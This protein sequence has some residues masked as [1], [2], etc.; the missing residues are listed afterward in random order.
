MKVIKE[1]LDELVP[2]LTVINNQSLQSGVFPNVWKEDLVT[3]TITKCGFDLAFKN[4]R[5]VSNL[6][7]A[8]KLVERAAAEQ[9]QSHLVKN[10][11]FPTLQSAYRPNHS[12]ETALLKSKMTIYGIWIKNTLRFLSFR[13]SAPPLTRL[14]S[15]SPKPYTHRILCIWK[16]VRLVRLVLIK[17]FSE[18]YSWWYIIRPVWY[19]LWGIPRQLPWSSVIRHLF[20]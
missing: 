4:F 15:N 1:C 12:T 10:N 20:Q 13:T 6:Q 9:L 7:F 18:S 5:P 2:L 3:P 17:S 19:P 11:L 16:S 8:S 14:T